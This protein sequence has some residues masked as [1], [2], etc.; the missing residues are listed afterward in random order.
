MAQLSKQN[1]ALNWT[2]ECQKAWQ[3]IKNRI[4]HAPIMGFGDFTKPIQMH[5]DACKNG[6]AAILTQERNGRQVLIDAISRTTT[7]PEKNNSSTKLECAC[8][9]WAAKRFKHY[10]YAAPLTEIITDSYGLQYLQQKNNESA[11]VQR[12]LCE[13]EGFT[14]KVKYRKG[15]ENIADFLSRQGDVAVPVQ[16][17][18][19][20][21]APRIDYR[22]LNKGVARSK[23]D[24]QPP[25]AHNGK[26]QPQ[27]NQ[28][29]QKPRE[30]VK[31]KTM[32]RTARED[33]R[34]QQNNKFRNSKRRA[35]QSLRD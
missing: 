27:K 21:G 8:V 5:T 17:R 7:K 16:T 20:R 32:R 12:W 26:A 10:L 29:A 13:M 25:Q 15:G 24:R 14:F 23:D 9:I 1:K 11:L 31:K 18:S 4:A 35:N 22:A 34:K 30:A 19:S 3:E 28:K 33:R 6:F 2:D